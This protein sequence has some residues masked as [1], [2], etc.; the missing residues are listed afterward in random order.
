MSVKAYVVTQASIVA[1]VLF[2]GLDPMMK[3]L[4]IVV[5][6][7]IS[8]IANL[9]YIGSKFRELITKAIMSDVHEELI[10]LDYLKFLPPPPKDKK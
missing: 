6:A 5:V 7:V 3:A 1:A 10:R 2:T 4:T 8:V 9:L